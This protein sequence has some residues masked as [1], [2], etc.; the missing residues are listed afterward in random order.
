MKRK[1]REQKSLHELGRNERKRIKK[2]RK[3]MKKENKRREKRRELEQYG[4]VD[5]V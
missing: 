5:F 3:K 1:L 2:K 4:L